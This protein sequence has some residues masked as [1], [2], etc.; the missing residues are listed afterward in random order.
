MP[1]KIDI[2]TLKIFKNQEQRRLNIGKKLKTTSLS[3]R[4]TGSEKEE[5]TS[6]W[7][8]LKIFET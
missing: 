4:L 5:C 3:L 1:A 7:S 2:D 8:L 6:T